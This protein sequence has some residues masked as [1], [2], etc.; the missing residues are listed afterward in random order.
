MEIR[1]IWQKKKRVSVGTD[2][3][4]IVCDICTLP[5]TFDVLWGCQLDILMSASKVKPH[6]F[7]ATV[8][9]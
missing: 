3:S 2:T 6:L 9:T 4:S 1:S 5:A 7:L 8:G